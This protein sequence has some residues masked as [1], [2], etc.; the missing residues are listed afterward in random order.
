[1]E[2]EATLARPFKL[3]LYAAFACFT[4]PPSRQP[5][6]QL[7]GTTGDR[8]P[9]YGSVWYWFRCPSAAGEIAGNPV[10]RL[11]AST[12]GQFVD[13]VIRGAKLTQWGSLRNY[14]ARELRSSFP[15]ARA[16]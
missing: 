8:Y 5:A 7:N 16:S 13:L 12:A 1:V 4:K 10:P 2:T 15:A 14:R 9:G 11:I 6:R 3:S